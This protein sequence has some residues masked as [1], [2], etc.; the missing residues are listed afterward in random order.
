MDRLK[1]PTSVALL[2]LCFTGCGKGDEDSIVGTWDATMLDDTAFPYT[3]VG[4]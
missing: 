3:E 2:G 4:Q 1:I